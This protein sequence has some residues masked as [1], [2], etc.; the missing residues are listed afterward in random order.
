M[1]ESKEVSVPSEEGE[2]L[3]TVTVEDAI[4]DEDPVV[5]ESSTS[6]S[7]KKKKKNKLKALLSHKPNTDV[8][9]Q[10]VEETIASTSNEE[11]K[12]LS[13]EEKQKLEMVIR[14][15]N[16]LLPGGGKELADHKFWKTQPVPKFG[17]SLKGSTDER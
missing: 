12:E 11:K 7:K 13:K 8:T 9:L 15:L 6:K 16:K 5:P 10:E 4:E 14:K 3:T 1:S 2:S 17:T